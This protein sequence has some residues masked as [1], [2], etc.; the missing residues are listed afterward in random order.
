[1]NQVQKFKEVLQLKEKNTLFSCLGSVR[2]LCA[3]HK[4][5]CVGTTF[6][7]SSSPGCC[8]SMT[9]KDVISRW[10]LQVTVTWIKDALDAHT[11]IP[12]YPLYPVT[13]AQQSTCK[14]AH[15]TYDLWKSVS[16][17]ISIKIQDSNGQTRCSTFFVTFTM[18]LKKK[19]EFFFKALKNNM[20]RIKGVSAKG[21]SDSS[22]EFEVNRF[23]LAHR[24]RDHIATPT[25]CAH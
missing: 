19:K 3:I 8:G 16:I 22:C 7:L 4:K 11:K 5:V 23:R 24:R 1:M 6:I 14:H 9:I 18:S 13:C 12:L 2:E 25:V 15:L 17:L 10:L 21:I 20:L